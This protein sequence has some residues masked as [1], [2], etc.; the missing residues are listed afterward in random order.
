M[1][2]PP[3]DSR[4]WIRRFSNTF[5]RKGEG[6]RGRKQIR[7]GAEGF[8]RFRKDDYKGVFPQNWEVGYAEYTVVNIGEDTS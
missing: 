6:V 8:T 5:V 3:P 2:P 1:D 4:I 7:Q